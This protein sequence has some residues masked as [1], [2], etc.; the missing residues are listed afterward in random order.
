MKWP[1]VF[2]SSYEKLQDKLTAMGSIN[3]KLRA[4]LIQAQK[5]DMPRDPRTGKWKSKN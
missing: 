1:F 4:D 2:R 3:A 5:N